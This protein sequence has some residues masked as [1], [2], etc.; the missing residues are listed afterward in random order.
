[1]IEQGHE[2]VHLAEVIGA[3]LRYDDPNDEEAVK[4][5]ETIRDRGDRAALSQY[6]GVAEDHPLVELV[7]KKMGG[8]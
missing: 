4:L 5:Q 7:L 1:M 3:V 6:A 2:P 8:D